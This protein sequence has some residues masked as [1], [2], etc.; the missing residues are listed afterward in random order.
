ML[1]W[2]SFD[3]VFCIAS[4][5]ML[6]MYRHKQRPDMNLLD[7]KT[8]NQINRSSATEQMLRTIVNK[9][10]RLCRYDCLFTSYNYLQR[11]Q[12]FKFLFVPHF[13]EYWDFQGMSMNRKK[14]L[15]EYKKVKNDLKGNCPQNTNKHIYICIWF[16]NSG[17]LFFLLVYKLKYIVIFQ[18]NLYV[19][20]SVL[21]FLFD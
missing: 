15:N 10:Y 18:N 6:I 4:G 2:Y 3:G 13:R 9:K 21:Y 5:L 14:S 16:L 19:Q 8:C 1:W 11:K 17:Y 12:S 20:C 7:R